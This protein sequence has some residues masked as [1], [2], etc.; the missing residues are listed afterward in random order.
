MKQPTML[1]GRPQASAEALWA[2]LDDLPVRI[3]FIDRERRLRY[4]NRQ[5][6]TFI[7]LPLSE[8]LGKTVAEIYGEQEAA[9]L[10][11]FGDRALR[12]ETVAWEGWV[13]FP[14]GIQRYVRRTYK[15]HWE[16]GKR[17]AG[18]F[19]L[20]SDITEHRQ[21]ETE[22]QRLAQL[23]RDAIESISNGFAVYDGSDRLVACNTAF[24]SLFRVEPQSLVGTSIE[25][26]F[27]RAQLRMRSFDGRLATDGS[28][29]LE[30][31]LQRLREAD[32]QPVDIEL[33]NGQWLQIT[34]HPTADGGRVYIRTDITRLKNTEALLRDSE[35]R[36]RDIV[37]RNPLPVWVN[38]IESG[39]ILY[40]S[41]AASTLVGRNTQDAGP[42]RATDYYA[43]IA[44]RTDYLRK[45]REH[46][47]VDG[48]ELRLKK[49]DGTEFWA[50][51]TARIF[52]HEGRELAVVSMVDL[53][54]RKARE[55]ELRQARETLEDAIESLAE[56]FA[57][58]DADRRL[59]MCNQR[60][61]DFNYL[62]ADTLVPGV[63]W[64]DFMRAGAERGQYV[65]AIGRV[66][67]YVQERKKMRAALV[68]HYEFQ[69]SDGRWFTGSV[70]RTRQ[71]GL[72]VIRVDS[73]E[74]KRMEQ[75]LRESEARFRS[76]TIAHPV[77]MAISTFTGK[78]LYVSQPF[79]DLFGMS[80]EEALKQPAVEYYKSPEGRAAF[81][82]ALRRTGSVDSYEV[83]ARRKDGSIFWAS[84]TARRS[85]FEGQD[86]IVTGFIDL[87]ERRAAEQELARQ[88][89]A[90]HQSEKL[91]ALGGLL[92]GVAHELNNPLSVVVG[93]SLLLRDADTDAK[94]QRRAERIANA[95]D[96]CSRIVKTFLAMARQNTPSYREANLNDI[97]ESALGITEY[98]LRSADIEIR[99]KLAEELPPVWGDPDQLT[100]VVMNLII[101]AEQAMADKIGKRSLEIVTSI[102]DNDN[103]V[104]LKLRDSGPGI[105]PEIRTRIFEPFFTTK[106]VGVGT[107]VGLSVSHAIV[108][109]HQGTIEVESE[110]GKGAMF[111]VSLPRAQQ[112]AAQTGLAPANETPRVRRKVL[113]VDDEPEVREVLADILSLDGHQIEAASSGNAALRILAHE[114]FDLILSDMRMPD[115]DGPG[116]YTRIKNAYP[117][118]VDRIIFITGD[119]LGPSIRAFLDQTGL[120]CLEKPFDPK[121]VRQLVGQ[122]GTSVDAAK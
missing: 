5:Y 79:A 98:A 25:E 94:T 38:E 54:E 66:E 101:N 17:V 110:A 77:P 12:G 104:Q 9:K 108:D 88:R 50:S 33:D 57:L 106:G 65:D 58:W 93:Q 10:H 120:P 45:L 22:Q 23:L 91:N 111:V 105:A 85:V 92:A 103:R 74:R 82:E 14:R 75:A 117:H 39:R 68:S 52:R 118:L 122:I 4:A 70:R 78:M 84:L 48:Y 27:S 89:E 64:E 63:R 8:I 121:E 46:G 67:E 53:T 87:T 3:S 81:V 55:A 49:V 28:P 16:D 116:L 83:E 86:A 21:A 102:E 41:P 35:R 69:Q 29:S 30:Q 6:A 73:T 20:V 97:V 2:M 11:P 100:Q 40:E 56:G 115:V 99:R 112:S 114:N 26:L 80:V 47:E 13:W 61:K 15:P 37:E 119:A 96:R 59:V 19:V 109:A 90:L 113:V 34:S 51:I 31:A 36:F 71:G 42:G 24:A 18:Y 60:Y 62:S 76:I 32:H 44:D 43:D 7:G 1:E 95:A 107:G 72:V